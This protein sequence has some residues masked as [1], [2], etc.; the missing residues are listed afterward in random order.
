[1]SAF[2]A[3]PLRK[4]REEAQSGHPVSYSTDEWRELIDLKLTAIGVER[5]KEKF[6]AELGAVTPLM[7]KIGGVQWMIEHGDGVVIEQT[8]LKWRGDESAKE[9]YAILQ[10][11]PVF[12]PALLRLAELKEKD[13]IWVPVI[14]RRLKAAIGKPDVEGLLR[15]SEKATKKY[16]SAA[17]REYAGLYAKVVNGAENM[18]VASTPLWRYALNSF[19]RL[20]FPP[21]TKENQQICR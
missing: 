3:L 11:N 15:I 9:C 19:G 5:E 6:W 8:L 14:S 1:M 4:A 17:W 20:E 7:A 10:V 2:D 12:S 18:K 16:G 21:A 13:G